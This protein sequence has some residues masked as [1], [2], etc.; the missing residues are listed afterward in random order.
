MLEWVFWAEPDKQI[1]RGLV[2][3]GGFYIVSFVLVW[4]CALGLCRMDWWDESRNVYVRGYTGWAVTLT[5]YVIINTVLLFMLIQWLKSNGFG[6]F[7]GSLPL[8]VSIL[9]SGI[10]SL[11]L[12]KSTKNKINQE[13]LERRM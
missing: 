6:I 10:I 13:T 12:L 5:L 1:I 11:N 4:L 2:V 3:T 9:I 7:Y 8:V